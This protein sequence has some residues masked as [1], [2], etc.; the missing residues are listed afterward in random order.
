MS[1]IRISAQA[2]PKATED[3]AQPSVTERK[4]SGHTAPRKPLISLNEPGRL[5]VADL[6]G[7]FGIAHSTLYAGLKSGRY[8]KA[9]GLDQTIPYWHTAT[10][11]QFLER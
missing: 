5:R 4:K 10:I 8:P 7:L 9:D 2:M 3:A 6:L 1:I 11:R